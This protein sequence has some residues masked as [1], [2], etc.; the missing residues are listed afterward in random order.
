MAPQTADR[1]MKLHQTAIVLDQVI[2]RREP[3]GTSATRADGEENGLLSI[4]APVRSELAR[5]SALQPQHYA[6]WLNLRHLLISLASDHDREYS[7]HYA[8]DDT[9]P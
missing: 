4:V 3:C 2:S 6:R 7:R 8:S 5:L 1:Q 9:H